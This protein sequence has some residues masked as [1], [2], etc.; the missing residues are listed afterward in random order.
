LLVV[1]EEV[2][3]VLIGQV[4]QVL[5]V[6]E[7]E[8]VAHQELRMGSQALMELSWLKELKVLEVELEHQV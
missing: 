1:E 2:Q 7:V 4:P 3:V 6:L 8:I 5:E